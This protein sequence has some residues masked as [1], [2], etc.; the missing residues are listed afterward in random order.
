[1]VPALRKIPGRGDRLEITLQS[2]VGI[3]VLIA[4]FS[5]AQRK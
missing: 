3:F 1:M 4:P 2:F 5:L